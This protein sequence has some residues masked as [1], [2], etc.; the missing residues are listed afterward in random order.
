[1]HT[2]KITHSEKIARDIMVT[3]IT[4]TPSDTPDNKPAD[5]YSLDKKREHIHRQVLSSVSHDL[6]TPLTSIIGSLEV[7]ER[8]KD[9]LS[10]E[11]QSTLIQVALQEAYRLDNF[12]TNILDMARFENSQVKAVQ[13]Q[14][15]I[16]TMLRNC[17]ARL[18]NRL[19]GSEVNIESTDV[20]K[21]IT[22]PVLLSHT[23]CH[24]LDNA[25][26][27]GGAPP[28]IHIEFGKDKNNE[29][30]I[31]IRD[32]GRGIAC[33]Q[34]DSIFLKYTRLADEGK[35][36][37][38]IGLGLAISCEIMKIINGSITVEN[39]DNSGAR[40]TLRFPT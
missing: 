30:F 2:H 38:G 1:V 15:E 35:Q 14:I 9:M 3:K 17:I 20:L 6:K 4:N 16:G 33:A 29:G 23:V 31:H 34:K 37:V 26:K 11:K 21:V 10:Q 12:I 24:V 13:E 36:S 40:F 18:S 28:I 8:M 32:N 27:Y 39:S 19:K 25:V 22:D 7:Y 5:A